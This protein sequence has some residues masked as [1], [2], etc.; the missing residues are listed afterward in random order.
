MDSISSELLSELRTLIE[1]LGNQGGLVSP[2]V[3]DTAQ[4]L[5][6]YPPQEGVVPGLKW[7]L[8][9]QHEDGGWGVQAVPSARSIPT[10][11][12]VLALYTYRHTY[13]AQNAIQAG[14]NFL[15]RN[16]AQWASLHIDLVPIAGEMILPYLLQEA[17]KMGL[18]IDQAPYARILELRHM[19]LR[20]LD[21]QPLPSNSAPTYSWEALGFPHR[22]EVLH[23]HTGVGHSPAA[24]AAWLHTARQIGEEGALCAKAEAYLARAAATTGTGIPGVVPMVYPITGFE[25]CYGLY[26]LL[27]TGILDHPELQDVVAPKVAEL[28]EMVEREQ[29]LSFGEEFVP[30]VDETAVAV[31]VLQAAKQSPDVKLVH[32]FWRNDHFYTYVHELNPSVFSNA[33]A[34]HA[35]VQC[36]ER[37]KSTEDFLIR[38]QTK[39]GAWVVDKW[40]TSWRSS[41]LEVIAALLPLGYEE[42]LRRAGQALIADQNPDGSWGP[43]GSASALE[44]AHSVIALQ[45]VASI[46]HLTEQMQPSLLSGRQWLWDHQDTLHTIE[47]AWLGKEVYSAIRVDHLYK[48]CAILSPTLRAKHPMQR[49]H[50]EIDAVY[51]TAQKAQQWN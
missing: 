16:A 15:E 13:N 21:N 9:Q 35:L 33:H 27:L 23:P 4:V 32:R 34:L 28:R 24:T 5:R 3:Y 36:N 26:A 2:S 44:T 51:A 11:A 50:K 25:L 7:L 43:S 19:K 29:G 48:L 10:L 39:S 31:S 45:L 14:L 6:L 40:H 18:V 1:Q 46:P 38:Q 12:A 37:C 8:S 20:Y 17:A 47:R 30:D 22:S 42:Q 41:T 49:E